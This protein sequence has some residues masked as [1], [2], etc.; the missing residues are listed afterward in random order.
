[1]PG[2]GKCKPNANFQEVT[3]ASR[4]WASEIVAKLS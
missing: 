2:T 1:L 3:Y 4:D